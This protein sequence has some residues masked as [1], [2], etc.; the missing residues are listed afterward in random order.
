MRAAFSLNYDKIAD[1][2]FH[3]I[4]LQVAGEHIRLP[5][6]VPSRE[7]WAT[8][9]RLL[10]SE[11]K[12]SLNEDGTFAALRLLH[13]VVDMLSTQRRLR[14]LAD[15]AGDSAEHPAEVVFMFDGFPVERISIEHFCV[16]TASLRPELSSQSEQLLRVVNCSRIKEN[17][18]QMHRVA[19]H[20]RLGADFNELVRSRGAQVPTDVDGEENFMHI[21]MLVAADKKGVGRG[22]SG[23][24]TVLCLVH[25]LRLATPYTAL[26]TN[27]PAYV[28]A[29]ARWRRCSAE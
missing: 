27:Q 4:W 1:R 17:N 7:L 26:E 22:S 13:V 20:N 15:G 5:E 16:A 21:E 25:M 28:L 12:I 9:L 2:Y 18:P 29:W 3:P 8:A 11:L 10:K 23:L 19:E 6:P 24:Q 14:M